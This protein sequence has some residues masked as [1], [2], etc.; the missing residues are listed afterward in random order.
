MPKPTCMRAGQV[1]R[2]PAKLSGTEPLTALLIKASGNIRGE[3]PL[4][5]NRA[6]TS[7]SDS[8]IRR[9][10]MHFR[11]ATAHLAFQA[12]WEMVG[13]GPQAFLVHYLDL[14]DSRFIQGTPLIFSMVS[15]SS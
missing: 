3:I 10:S 8:G 5:N 1:K 4:L 13:N 14:N 9:R 12:C 11:Q 7:T 2:F 15:I 6:A